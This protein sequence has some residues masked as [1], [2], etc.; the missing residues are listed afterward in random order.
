MLPALF[1]SKYRISSFPTLEAQTLEKSNA[2]RVSGIRDTK[3]PRDWS[4]REKQLK[5]FMHCG[6]CDAA[7]LR[8]WRKCET[9]FPGLTVFGQAKAD[10]ADQSVYVGFGNA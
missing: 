4:C 3:D 10:V 2:G 5:C 6:A 7:A 8:R 1:A 9:N